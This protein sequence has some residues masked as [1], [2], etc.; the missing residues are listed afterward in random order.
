MHSRMEL[1]LFAGRS[2]TTKVRILD[3]GFMR[4][5][6][7]TLNINIGQEGSGNFGGTVF[8]ETI[9]ARS[10]PANMLFTLLHYLFKLTEAFSDK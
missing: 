10:M 3:G 4:K 6:D 5:F 1:R 7:I 8:S 9:T 2:S